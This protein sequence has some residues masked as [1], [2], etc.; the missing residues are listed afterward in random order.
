MRHLVSRTPLRYHAFS[1]RR[2]LLFPILRPSLR[3]FREPDLAIDLFE[4]MLPAPSWLTV[5]ILEIDPIWDP[6]R[7]HLRFQ[8]LLEKY[9]DDVEH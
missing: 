8:A 9:A 7:D 3:P 1:F 2:A 5:H 4:E 6:L